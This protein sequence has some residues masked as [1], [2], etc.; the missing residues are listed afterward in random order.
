MFA[1]S[2]FSVHTLPAHHL[3]TNAFLPITKGR[4]GGNRINLE[5]D[6]LLVRRRVGVRVERVES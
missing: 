1:S 5:G 3:L 6:F 2:E 4:R